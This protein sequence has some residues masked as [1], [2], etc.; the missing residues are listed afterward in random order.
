[1]V[2]EHLQQDRGHHKSR[3]ARLLPCVVSVS[4]I[5]TDPKKITAIQDWI[6]P[7]SVKELQSFLGFANYYRRFIQG[8]TSIAS[9]LTDLLR[10]GVDF[11]WGPAQQQAIEQMKQSLTSSPTLSYPVPTCPNVV[12]TDASD[13]AIGAVLL[14]D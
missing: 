13:R 6:A 2:L 3:Y 9:P 10:N 7:T 12:V 8:Y 11:N 4:G 1:M 5:R 14:Q